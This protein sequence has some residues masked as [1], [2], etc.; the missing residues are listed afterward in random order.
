MAIEQLGLEGRVHVGKIRQFFDVPGF[1]RAADL[2][3]GSASPRCEQLAA[4]D[5]GSLNPRLHIMFCTHSVPTSAA[6]EAGPRRGTT[7][8]LRFSEKHSAG[9]S[10]RAFAGSR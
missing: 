1:S 6:N 7:R 5:S 2:A 8:R 10:R 9:R 3:E 4:R